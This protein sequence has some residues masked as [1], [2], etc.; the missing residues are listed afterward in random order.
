MSLLNRVF[1][2]NIRSLRA[3]LP[4]PRN[5]DVLLLRESLLLRF[6]RPHLAGLSSRRPEFFRGKSLSSIF[7]ADRESF[8]ISDRISIVEN[9]PREGADGFSCWSRHGVAFHCRII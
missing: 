1:G 8:Q 2:C 9:R 6:V 7:A 4:L 3:A 5:P